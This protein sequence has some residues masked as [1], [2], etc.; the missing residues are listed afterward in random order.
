MPNTVFRTVLIGLGNIGLKYDINKSKEDFIQ[1]HARAFTLNPGF[2]LLAGVDINSQTCSSFTESYNIKSYIDLEYALLEVKPDLVILS[3]PTHKQ[4]ETIKKI[5]NCFLPKSILC[6]KPMGGSV[7]HGL[8]ILNVCRENNINLYVNYVRRSLPAAKEIKNRIQSNVIKAPIKS[9]I[10][11]SKGISHN[12]SHFINLMEYWFGKCIDIKLISKGRE[13]KDFGFEPQVYI[14]FKNAESILIP[15]WEESYSH[16]TIE[17]ISAS[18]R[19]YWNQ[20]TLEWKGLDSS[21]SMDNHVFLS[22]ISEAIFTGSN[23][24]QKY[25]A[26]ELYSAMMERPNSIASGDEALETL[27]TLDRILS[28]K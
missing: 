5:V 8:K 20:N 18:G 26:D 22:D 13:Y 3:V 6:E 2:D 19:L 1:T 24:Y 4:L 21:N 12:G 7:D 10:W 28:L 9:V 27:E 23:K 25:V 14:K 15:A 16:Y 17:I 11:Y